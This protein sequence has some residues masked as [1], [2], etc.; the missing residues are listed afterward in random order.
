MT[1]EE[2][3]TEAAQATSEALAAEATIAAYATQQASSDES[4]DEQA[5][6]AAQAAALATEAALQAQATI[7]A[8]ETREAVIAAI[9]TENALTGAN[10]LATARAIAAN[11]ATAV[12]ASEANV[13]TLQQ[14][15]IDAEVTATA[16]AQVA[17]NSV[18]DPA[19]Q[20]ITIQTDLNGMLS[21]D[22]DTLATVRGQLDTLLSRYPIGC[23]AGFALISGNAPDIPEGIEL[24]RGIEELLREVRSDIFTADTGFEHFALPNTQPFGQASIQISLP[25]A[26]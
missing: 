1:A 21:G 11:N 15:Q 23:R 13:A 9:A 12:A 26:A 18:L 17:A 14:Q 10:D 4:L 19:S 3:A 16:L 25:G 2:R 6:E 8:L 24:A 22:D 7:A 5:R 20:A